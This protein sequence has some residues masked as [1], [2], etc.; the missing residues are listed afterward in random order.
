MTEHF[1]TRKYNAH[2]RYMSILSL[3]GEGRSVIILP[4]LTLNSGWKDIAAKIERFIYQTTRLISIAPPRNT[5]ENLP[6]AQVVKESKWQSNTLREAR[7]NTNNGEISVMEPTGGEDTGLLK[8]CIIGSFGKEINERPTLADI[9]RWASASWNKAYGVN[10]YEMTGNMFLFEFPNRFMAEQIVQGE[11]RWKNSSFIWNGGIILL[12][13]FQT[14]KLR[15]HAGLEP[16]GFLY[17][18]GHKR[19]SKK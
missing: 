5:V 19:S 10:I 11:W 6:Y 2:G 13:A 8:R 1:C 4:E 16:W 17:I 7:V 12:V 14:H 9:R 15:K 18:Y 3:K